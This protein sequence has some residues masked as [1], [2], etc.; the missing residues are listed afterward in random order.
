MNQP[1]FDIINDRIREVLSK[2]PQIVFATVFG[3][4]ATGR[5]TPLSDVDIAIA[6]ERELSFAT[7]MDLS[8]AL[9]KALGHEV[10]LVDLHAVSGLI[11]K[12]ALC[13]GEIIHRG[14]PAIYAGLLKKMW[15]NQQDMMPHY[16]RILK[17]NCERFVNG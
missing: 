2:F 8:V 1:S 4:A 15:Y 10:D 12:E 16:R 5:I 13:S 6:G 7:K 17:N 14:K 3:S 11:L 9:S